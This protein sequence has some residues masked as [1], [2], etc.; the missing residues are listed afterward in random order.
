M[1]KMRTLVK[2]VM[3]GLFAAL[4]SGQGMCETIDL[5]FSLF[6]PHD[7]TLIKDVITPW[8]ED[9][10]K[11]TK[12][13]VKISVHP[14]CELGPVTEQYDMVLK[15]AADMAM[16]VPS[17]TPERFP[18]ISVFGLPSMVKNAESGSIVLWEIYKSF[19]QEELKD[20]KVLWMFVQS[21]GQ[22]LSKKPVKTL[23]DLKG[24]KI[25]SPGTRISKLIEKLGAVPVDAPISKAYELLAS[26]E[27]EA[28]VASW[29]AIRSFK[30]YEQCKFA[31]MA[32][33]YVLPF[34][35]GMNKEKYESLPSDVKKVFEENSGEGI[36]AKAGKANDQGGA[37]A[38]TL[39]ERDG[40]QVIQLSP[41]ERDRWKKIGL[42]VGDH[43]A[44]EMSA[45]GL[46]GARILETT[47][48]LLLQV[49]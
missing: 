35:I 6:I 10:E 32:D 12:G 49:Q 1:K 14:N 3:I 44:E 31:T 13:K 7:H 28:V 41:E 37:D 45:K 38:K 43:W 36:S 2:V 17:Y 25:R 30:F 5:K 8:V 4:F 18:L 47:T 9:I 34:F 15:G 29:E 11:L 23:E 48:D 21:P 42:T 19:L 46:P 33:L 27:A 40:G 20:V 24:M 22:I 39:F 16:V 26:G